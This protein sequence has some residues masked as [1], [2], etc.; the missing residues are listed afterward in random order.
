MQIVAALHWLLSPFLIIS[1]SV[2]TVPWS[3]HLCKFLNLRRVLKFNQP[4][5]RDF[6]SMG[7]VTPILGWIKYERPLQ[8]LMRSLLE[9]HVVVGVVEGVTSHHPHQTRVHHSLVGRPTWR[10]SWWFDTGEHPESLSRGNR[11]RAVW[12]WDRQRRGVTSLTR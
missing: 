7:Q 12:A 8:I 9:D 5:S 1:T 6:C 10:L 4:Y 3:N 11:Q 2:S